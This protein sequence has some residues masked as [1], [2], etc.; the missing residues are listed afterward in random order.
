MVFGNSGESQN[1]IPDDSDAVWEFKEN[2]V[3]F[4]MTNS[5]TISYE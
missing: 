4:L 3:G 2:S 5:T 1:N